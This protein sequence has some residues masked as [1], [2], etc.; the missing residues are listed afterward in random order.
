MRETIEFR[1]SESWAQEFLEPD[2]GESLGGSVRKVVLPMDDPRVKLISDL[3]REFWKRGRAFFTFAHV[4]RHYTRKE[5]EAA[6]VLQLLIRPTFEPEGEM[7]GTEYDDAAACQHCGAEAPQLT[8]LHLDVRRIPKKKDLAV[9]IAGEMVI[10]ARLAKALLE[11]GITG[12]EYRPVRHKTGVVSDEWRQLVVTAP[13][14]N[15]V[16]PTRAGIDPFDLDR[17]GRYRCPLKHVV[18]LNR[19]S[20]LWIKRVRYNSSDWV[21]TRQ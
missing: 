16:P 14:V 15:I 19:L 18:G 5:L 2:L 21:T 7:Y 4:S 20:E 10:S 9:T 6:E 1:I 17:E 3:D 11:H 12:A 8:D 13:P